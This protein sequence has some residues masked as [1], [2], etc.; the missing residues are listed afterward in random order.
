MLLAGDQ[1]KGLSIDLALLT[2]R[3]GVQ[4]VF[5]AANGVNEAHDKS[6][7]LALDGPAP[8]LFAGDVWWS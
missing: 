4:Q 5:L 7:W 3:E 1:G 2:G 8:T 6:F